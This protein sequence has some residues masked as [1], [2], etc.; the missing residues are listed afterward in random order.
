M[1]AAKIQALESTIILVLAPEKPNRALK[2]FAAQYD[3]SM[4][5][6]T[7]LR[8]NPLWSARTEAGPWCGLP[9]HHSSAYF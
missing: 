6:S 2:S 3:S 5:L 8:V 7:E 9:L 1:Q 4:H